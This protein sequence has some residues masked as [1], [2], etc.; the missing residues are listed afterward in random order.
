LVN[1][2]FYNCVVRDTSLN[3]VEAENFTFIKSTLKSVKFTS[4]DF[5][6]LIFDK[7]RLSSIELSRSS[8]FNLKI[9]KLKNQLWGN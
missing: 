5:D 9:K 1:F 3:R 2:S 6:R 7:S 4:G 8:I